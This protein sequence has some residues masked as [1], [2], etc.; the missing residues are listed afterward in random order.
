MQLHLTEDELWDL[1]FVELDALFASHRKQEAYQDYRFGKLCEI[2]ALSQG[3]KTNNGAKISPELF[4]PSIKQ[5][6]KETAEQSPEQM[7]AWAEQF[8]AA[9]KTSD[10]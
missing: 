8:A 7:L 4:F 5:L 10:K 3:V 6:T 1:A 2:I 9:N